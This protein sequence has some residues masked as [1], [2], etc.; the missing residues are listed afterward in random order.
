MQGQHEAAQ[1]PFIR[2]RRAI[3]GMADFV[4]SFFWRALDRPAIATALMLTAATLFVATGVFGLGR[5]NSGLL[6]G[7]GDFDYLY[8]AGQIWLDGRS[9]YV[10]KDFVS[11]YPGASAFAYPPPILPLALLLAALPQNAAE[12]LMHALNLSAVAAIS[13]SAVELSSPTDRQQARR[14]HLL[15]VLVLMSAPFTSH[16]MWLGQ[17]SLIGVALVVG[18][19]DAYRRRMLILAGVLATLA[20]AKPQLALLPVLLLMSRCDARFLVALSISS[21]VFLAWPAWTAGGPMALVNQYL[22]SIKA[23]GASPYQAIDFQHVFGLRSLAASLGSDLPILAALLIV[24]CGSLHVYRGR[25]RSEADTL[26]ILFCL[27]LLLLFAHDYDLVALALLVPALFHHLIQRNLLAG[28]C[29][30]VLVL[31]Y[32]PQRF[33]LNFDPTWLIRY[34]ELLC[35]ALLC[36]LVMMNQLWARNGRV[37]REGGLKHSGS[38]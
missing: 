33:V 27:S 1:E 26:A 15:T 35:L 4:A 24:V 12:L 32:V 21:L 10:V 34:R 19:F 25:L 23:Y 6:G 22:A 37:N 18:A 3:D 31:L 36:G 11:A 16:V 29:L 8:L 9:P 30:A 17:T 14:L 28:I 5:S 38:F 7:G 20:L 13:W 2:P